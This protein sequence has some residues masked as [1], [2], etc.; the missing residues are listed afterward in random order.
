MTTI[1]N[2]HADF[3]RVAKRAARTVGKMRQSKGAAGALVGAYF[4]QT[5]GHPAARLFGT[6][7]CA[8]EGN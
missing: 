5:I 1:M 3:E 7:I 4:C 6:V 8:I 2:I